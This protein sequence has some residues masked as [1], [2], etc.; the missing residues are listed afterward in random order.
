[1]TPV[2]PEINEIRAVIKGVNELELGDIPLLSK[3]GQGVVTKDA[4]PPCR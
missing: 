1:M 3:E 4:K 2:F